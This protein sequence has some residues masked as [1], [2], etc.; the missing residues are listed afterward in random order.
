MDTIYLPNYPKISTY[1]YSYIIKNKDSLDR[2]K[3]II[4][5]YYLLYLY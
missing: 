3:S 5:L 4:Y 2:N 1:R